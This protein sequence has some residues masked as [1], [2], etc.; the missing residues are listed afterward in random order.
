MLKVLASKQ[1]FKLVLFFGKFALVIFDLLFELIFKIF[2]IS[3]VMSHRVMFGVMYQGKLEI[4]WQ[5]GLHIYKFFFNCFKTFPKT[6]YLTLK[7][8]YFLHRFP[9]WLLCLKYDVEHSATIFRTLTI[10]WLTGAH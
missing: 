7:A 8:L 2:H 9:D 6:F 3:V 10:N 1:L 4:F 5:T